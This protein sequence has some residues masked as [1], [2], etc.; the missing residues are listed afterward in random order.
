MSKVTKS[1]EVH[2]KNE[3]ELL[4]RLGTLRRALGER[5]GRIIQIAWS[6][7]QDEYAAS[8]V[9]EVPLG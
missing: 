9:Y 1:F 7:S 4:R 2:A 8:V 5:D 3:M 6:R